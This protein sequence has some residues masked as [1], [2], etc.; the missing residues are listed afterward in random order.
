MPANLKLA[1]LPAYS[2]ELNPQ[3]NL[4]DEIHERIFKNSDLKSIDEVDAKLE[5]AAL[6]LGRNPK[7][8]KA[9]NLLSLHCQI[10]LIWKWYERPFPIKGALCRSD[11][12]K[13]TITSR[14]LVPQEQFSPIQIWIVRYRHKPVQAGPHMHMGPAWHRQRCRERYVD[15]CFGV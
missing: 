13:S 14:K 11:D 7:L 2:P 8:V 10:I 4:W 3:E 5:E 1:F 12:I 15:Q 9:N 6:Y